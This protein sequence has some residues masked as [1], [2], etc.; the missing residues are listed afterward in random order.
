MIEP[1]IGGTKRNWFEFDETRN[2]NR[3]FSKSVSVLSS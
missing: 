2:G 1:R 3:A